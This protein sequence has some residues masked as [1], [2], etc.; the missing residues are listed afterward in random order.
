MTHD[1]VPSPAPAQTEIEDLPTRHLGDPAGRPPPPSQAPSTPARAARYGD[2]AVIACDGLVRIYKQA[3]LE[4]VALQGL[5]LLVDGG[6]MIA[7]VGASGSGKSTLLNILG[8]MDVPSA[9]RSSPATTLGGSATRSGRGSG[10]GSSGSSGS[11]RPGTCCRTSP[12]RRTSR[13]R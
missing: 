2:G 4:V 12:P 3:E 11:R 13:C 6:E 5:D 8:G 9:G 1:A 7:I 10:G